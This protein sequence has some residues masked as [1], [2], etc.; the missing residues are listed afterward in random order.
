MI[1]KQGSII[2]DLWTFY[3]SWQKIKLAMLLSH[4]SCVRL[5]VTPWTAAHQAPPSMGFSRQ[6]YW[7][8]AP[9]PGTSTNLRHSGTHY[10]YNI[11]TLTSIFWHSLAYSRTHT[12]LILPALTHIYIPLSLNPHEQS[13]ELHTLPCLFFIGC[14]G[15]SDGKES[16]FY[17]GDP[18]SIPG[19]GRSPGKGH[20]NPLQ[21]SCPENPHGQRSLVG[22]KEWDTTERLSAQHWN[23]MFW[24]HSNTWWHRGLATLHILSNI[25]FN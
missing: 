1:R 15:G 24:A 23:K 17:V 21:Y 8:G 20:G 12:A 14:P 18:G 4:F 7:S 2:A 16:A 9:L 10:L 13:L 19:L 3:W 5:C 6:E 22:C 11:L 25:H